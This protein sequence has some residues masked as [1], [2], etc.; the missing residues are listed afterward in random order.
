MPD[1]ARYLQRCSY[2]LRQGEPVNDIAFYL[3][4]SDAYAAF[5]PGN[6]NLIQGLRRR[7]GPDAVGAVLDAGFNM[8]FFDDDVL[9]DIG[10]IDDGAL[11]LGPNRYRAVVLPNVERIPPD[12]Y[13]MLEE[14]VR[15]GGRVIATKRLPSE[16]RP[17]W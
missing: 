10:S 4:V 5:S 14:F 12:T 16:A 3:P 8:D 6:A 7:V 17:L 13:R 2:M 15:S 11:V 1:V 9:R